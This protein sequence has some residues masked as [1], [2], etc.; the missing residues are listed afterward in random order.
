LNELRTNLRQL[1]K[2]LNA[3]VFKGAGPDFLR[4]AVE[5]RMSQVREAIEV[6]EEMVARIDGAHKILAEYAYAMEQRRASG[7]GMADIW[8]GA[9]EIPA[10]RLAFK[11]PEGS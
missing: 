3:L 6:N 8:A 1:T 2:R 11:W 7:M 4:A 5:Q 10:S 9:A